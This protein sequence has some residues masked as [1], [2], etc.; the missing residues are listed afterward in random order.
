M[1]LATWLTQAA[2]EEQTSVLLVILKVFVDLEF[3]S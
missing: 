3:I 1:I 2:D